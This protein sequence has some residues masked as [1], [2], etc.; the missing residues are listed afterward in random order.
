MKMGMKI[1]VLLLLATVAINLANSK[2]VVA[3][4]GGEEDSGGLL[5]VVSVCMVK[6]NSFYFGGNFLDIINIYAI[7]YFLSQ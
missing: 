3:D 7:K 4:V 5:Y 6:Y 2:E 1:L